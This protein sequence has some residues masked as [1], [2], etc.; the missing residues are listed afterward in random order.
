[1]LFGYAIPAIG[2]ALDFHTLDF[3]HTWHIYKCE[4]ARLK[5]WAY[6]DSNIESNYNN[7]SYS[8]G[9]RLKEHEWVICAKKSG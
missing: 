4:Q 1:M 9:F 7:F 8:G 5:R 3:T 2:C 6:L